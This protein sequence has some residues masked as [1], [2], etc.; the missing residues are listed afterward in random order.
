MPKGAFG[1]PDGQPHLREGRPSGHE[2]AK[3]NPSLAITRL[4]AGGG[5]PY[6]QRKRFGQKQGEGALAMRWPAKSLPSSFGH[7]MAKGSHTP[8][9]PK[10]K[11][12]P[13]PHLPDPTPF[14][15]TPHPTYPTPFFRWGRRK[16]RRE[17]L[18]GAF[19]TPASPPTRPF[20]NCRK[21]EKKKERE[22]K[23]RKANGHVRVLREG[24]GR[25]GRHPK[26]PAGKAVAKGIG[27][28]PP[29]EGGRVNLGGGRV[30][31][32]GVG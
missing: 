27:A 3:S 10:G 31:R 18:H 32:V 23:E 21:G 20:L 30:S 29:L 4:K 24:S 17:G 22:G 13:L 19:F 16:P 9:W 15:P 1:H 8:H 5:A 2:M 11:A 6:G 7:H 14:Y 12:I 26:N 28:S 25:W